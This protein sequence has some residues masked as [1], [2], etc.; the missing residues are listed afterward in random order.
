MKLQSPR[1]YF[2]P[3][4]PSVPT[5]VFLYSFYFRQGHHAEITCNEAL[6]QQYSGSVLVKSF[7]SKWGRSSIFVCFFPSLDSWLAAGSFFATV[8]FSGDNLRNGSGFL[9][10]RI[11]SVLM[12]DSEKDDEGRD[13]IANGFVF[14]PP[15]NSFFGSYERGT[16]NWLFLA[17]SVGILGMLR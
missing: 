14:T 10:R 11:P 12:V 15:P 2:P 1:C 9:V 16:K 8:G 4:S 5:L 6:L 17:T 3:I 13:G 7:L